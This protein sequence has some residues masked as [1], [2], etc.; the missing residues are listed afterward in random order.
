MSPSTERYP[1]IPVTPFAHCSLFRCLGRRN[2]RH[3]RCCS[4]LPAPFGIPRGKL[5]RTTWSDVSFSLRSVLCVLTS[6]SA[7]NTVE[8]W[9]RSVWLGLVLEVQLSSS[10]HVDC[11]E[12]QRL[13]GVKTTPSVRRSRRRND[14]DQTTDRQGIVPLLH[15]RAQLD[16]LD[17]DMLC[18]GGGPARWVVVEWD[19]GRMGSTGKEDQ[20]GV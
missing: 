19:R 15:H 17:L 10:W 9:S 16:R 13:R 2:P 11:F 7:M 4:D 6:A 18:R 20:P 3:S 14:E 1:A 8:P 12:A 5:P